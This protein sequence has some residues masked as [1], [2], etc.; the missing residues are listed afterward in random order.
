MKERERESGKS[1]KKNGERGGNNVS[2]SDGA[3]HREKEK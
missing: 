3:I 1:G 2:L